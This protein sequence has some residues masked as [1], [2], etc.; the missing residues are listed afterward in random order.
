MRVTERWGNAMRT[1]LGRIWRD[2]VGLRHIDSYA[3]AFTAVALA[4]LTILGDFVSDSMRWAA[5]LAG[6]GAL[7]YQIT[8]PGDES[9]CADRIVRDRSAFED[10]SLRDRIKDA[11][12]VWIF[13]PSAVNFLAPS[14]C[15]V[16][17]QTVLVKAE[18]RLRVVVLDPENT[19]AIALAG[20]QLDDSL[21]YPMQDF[22]SSLVATLA[23]LRAMEMWPIAGKVE[24][25]L[26]SYNPGFSLV[27]IDPHSGRGA[28]IVEIHGFRGEATYS[29]M[30]LEFSFRDSGR[31]FLYWVKQFEQMW[32]VGRHDSQ[33]KG[34]V[35]S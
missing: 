1:V 25:R 20:R 35:S 13:A 14:N 32:H 26:L 16:I 31:W 3:I 12:E 24:H 9:D 10:L 2:L 33:V 28:A 11:H 6:I 17:R 30:H 21:E 15:E 34:E 19:E 4:I 27:V 23:Q 5:V 29:R 22:A 7:V 18:G 8:T